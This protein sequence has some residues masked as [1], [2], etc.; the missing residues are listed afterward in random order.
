MVCTLGVRERMESGSLT[1]E[2][3]E[4]QKKCFLLSFYM[5][6]SSTYKNELLLYLLNDGFQRCRSIGWLTVLLIQISDLLMGT[7]VNGDAPIVSM[8]KIPI[9]SFFVSTDC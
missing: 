8:S 6:V 5:S 7:T 2:V 9:I 3:E 1:I 4:V